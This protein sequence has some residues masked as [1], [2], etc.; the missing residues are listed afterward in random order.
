MYFVI[1]E[2]MLNQGAIV[3]QRDGEL[4]IDMPYC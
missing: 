3:C 4:G 2:C 1:L